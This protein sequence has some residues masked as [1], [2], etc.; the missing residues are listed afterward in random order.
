MLPLLGSEPRK[1]CFGNVE[2]KCTQHCRNLLRQNLE[3]FSTYPAARKKMWEV[4]HIST[5]HQICRAGCKV[6][7]VVI[8]LPYFY[9]PYCALVDA[10]CRTGAKALKGSFLLEL[11]RG[12]PGRCMHWSTWA[13]FRVP[14]TL[15]C[16]RPPQIWSGRHSFPCPYW[17]DAYN[18]MGHFP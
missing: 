16:V 15:W 7:Q 12:V 1:F 8:F 3:M 10:D 11:A 2:E 13:I 18:M 9:C 5:W 6:I 17:F 14:L 4:H